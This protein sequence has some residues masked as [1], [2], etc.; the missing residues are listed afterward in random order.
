MIS[1][2]LRNDLARLYPDKLDA[3]RVVDDAGIKREDID[4]ST[5]ARNIWHQVLSEAEKPIR[6][7]SYWRS[8]V[9]I[10]RESGA[11]IVMI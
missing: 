7:N 10:I 6:L 9:T 8:S 11:F 1:P 4:F 2:H 5:T 3:Q